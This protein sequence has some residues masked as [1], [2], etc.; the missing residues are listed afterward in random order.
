MLPSFF[1]G[2]RNTHTTR[3][4]MV[5]KPNVVM[6]NSAL[7]FGIVRRDEFRSKNINI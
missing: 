6:N 4:E 1:N 5:F 3:I 7:L 2:R